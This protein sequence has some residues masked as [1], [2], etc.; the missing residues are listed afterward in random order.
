VWHLFVALHP[1]RDR[2][3]NELEDL[4]IQTGLHYPV[5][6]HLQQAYRDLGHGPGDF[7][8]AERIAAEG[9]SLPLFPE[10]T[11]DQQD[12]VVDALSR[13]LERDCEACT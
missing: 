1:R 10:M 6:V 2:I 13:V 7:P 8:V 3:R 12:R 4:G 9:F 11:L 5:P